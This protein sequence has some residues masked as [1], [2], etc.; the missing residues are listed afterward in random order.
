MSSYLPTP[1]NYHGNKDEA[2][3]AKETSYCT[4]GD[5]GLNEQNPSIEE[6]E[7]EA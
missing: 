7:L 3:V 2:K 4:E 6:K 5:Y 1:L